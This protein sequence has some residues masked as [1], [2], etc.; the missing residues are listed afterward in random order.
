MKSEI[1]DELDVYVLVDN[2]SDEHKRAIEVLEN[3][4]YDGSSTDA[5]VSRALK[6]VK[7]IENVTKRV[8]AEIK[9]FM[10]L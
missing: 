10:G 8:K 4:P 9:F 3:Y 7:D 5:V 6:L 2:L 1:K